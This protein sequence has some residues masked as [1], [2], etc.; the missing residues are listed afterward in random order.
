M[1]ALTASVDWRSVSLPGIDSSTVAIVLGAGGAIG[2]ATARALAAMGAAVAVATRDRD[3]S[4][5]VAAEITEQA[6]P[7][8]P[9][10]PVV[11]DMASESSLA[12]MAAEVQ[13]H[14][15]TPTVLVNS[16]AIG[17]PH[18][19]ITEVPRADLSTLFEVNVVGAFGAVAAVA[20]AM[21]KAGYGRIVNVGSVA[22]IKAMRGGVAYGVTKGAVASLTEQL[23]AELAGDGITVNSVSPGQTPTKLR[24]IHEAAGAPQGEAGGSAAAIPVGRRGLLDDY[25]GAILFLSSGLVGYI[26][27]VNIPVEGGVR[28]VR[29]KSF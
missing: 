1:T 4:T 25:V 13:E 21:R 8:R 14:L 29:P 23:A 2:G 11:A 6:K 12:A 3:R 17:A 27:G 7:P 26:T 15:G 20:P 18:A 5:A 9:A 19:D 22:G 10:L 24:D 16:A 28:L